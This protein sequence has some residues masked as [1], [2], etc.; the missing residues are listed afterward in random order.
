M[1]TNALMFGGIVLGAVIYGALGG[2]SSSSS[3]NGSCSQSKTDEEL[4][5]EYWNNLCYQDQ[6]EYF[7]NNEYLQRHIDT[8]YYQDRHQTAKHVA[9]L[10]KT[11]HKP[12]TDKYNRY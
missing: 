8:H 1:I 9:E 4:T 12:F 10:S 11:Y 3:G 6:E 5:Y 7:K 2:G